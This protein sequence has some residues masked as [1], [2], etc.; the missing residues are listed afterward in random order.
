MEKKTILV[1]EDEKAIADIL[2]FN[3]EREGY[4]TLAAYDGNDGLRLAQEGA[5]D[6]ILLDVMLPG[7]DGFEVCKR[8]R[9]DS[10]TP[11]IMLTA[12]E[13]ET[14]KV[15]GLELGADDYITKPFSMR[16]LMARVKAN[17]RRTLSGEEREKQPAQ[18]GGGL[19]ISQ[20]N[21]MVYKNSRALEL[22][23][24]EFDI[25]CFLAQAPGK[26]F[27]REELM[28]KV[29]GYEYYGDLR[30]VDVAIRRLR[31]KVEDQPASPRY[32]MTK[33]GMGY[34]FADEG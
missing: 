15:M 26:V 3:L 27:S 12:R 2:V 23:A 5:P 10:D 8:V 16:E 18:Q 33:R 29:W 20:E 17:M 31:E 21:G 24:R 34:Y 13:E 4:A 32:V 14:D 25:L 7:I 28:E 19:R 1:V 22:S 30:A 9:A 11:I 6:L